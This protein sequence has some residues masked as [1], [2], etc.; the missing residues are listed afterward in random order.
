MSTGGF[1]PQGKEYFHCHA[2][3]IPRNAENEERVV[4]SVSGCCITSHIGVCE[5]MTALI[6][7]NFHPYIRALLPLNVTGSNQALLSVILF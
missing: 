2:E 5:F 6:K 4:S 3:K 7:H 1:S